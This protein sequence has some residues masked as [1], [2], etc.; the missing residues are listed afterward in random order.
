VGC[1]EYNS[2][3]TWKGKRGGEMKFDE[4]G[5]WT[6]IKLAI[7]K[8]YASAYSINIAGQKQFSFSHVYIDA[9]SGS[10]LHISRT[11]GEFI[12][13]SPLN[14]LN[15]KPP[16]KEYYFIDLDGDKIKILSDLTK[17]REDV[18]LF[19]GDCNTVLLK[20]VFPNV[21]YSNYRR[22]LCLLDPYG[23]DLNWEVVARAGSM[24]SIEIFLNFPVADMNRNVLW[25]NPDGVSQD[26]I[27]RMNSFW[28]NESWREVAYDTQGNLFG[29]PMKT[30]NET[31]AFAY[32]DRLKNVA[33]F[34]H[35]P[36]PIPMRNSKGAIVYYLF[37]AS[38]KPVAQGIVEDIFMKYRNMG[39]R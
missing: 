8:E 29:M 39:E 5:N 20:E 4:V 16:F 17:G 33:G 15:V 26:Q 6:E 21:L 18:H 12:P 35:V 24:Q 34:L 32:R 1:E 13:G 37:F 31:I 36:D 25:R 38:H 3:D 7:V 22:G 30:E 19:P 9:F 28:G 27:N 2:G 23:L 11:K 10:G 14:A